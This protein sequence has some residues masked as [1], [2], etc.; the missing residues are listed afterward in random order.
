MSILH[1][2]NYTFKAIPVKIPN[3][4]FSPETDKLLDL[5]ENAFYGNVRGLTLP[6]SRFIVT[7]IKTV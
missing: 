3:F 1:K 7:V 6:D 5:Y 4:F 2:Q